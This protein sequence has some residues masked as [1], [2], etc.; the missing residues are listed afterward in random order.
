MG[1]QGLDD[2]AGIGTEFMMTVGTRT[3]KDE[4]GN[5]QEGRKFSKMR[6]AA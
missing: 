3:Y 5:D 6:E 4:E 1:P 2:E